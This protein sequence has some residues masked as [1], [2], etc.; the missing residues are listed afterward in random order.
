[1]GKLAHPHPPGTLFPHIYDSSTGQL[2]PIMEAH[3]TPGT[4]EICHG[5]FVLSADI[6][7]ARCPRC[8]A[9]RGVWK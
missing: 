2:R 7:T 9:E 1:M 5:N 8:Q 6:Q 3:L 4:R